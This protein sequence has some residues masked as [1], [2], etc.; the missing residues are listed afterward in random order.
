M[1]EN[2]ANSEPA[3][4]DVER[5]SRRGGLGLDEWFDRWPELFT[6]RWPET[7]GALPF[8]ESFRVEERTESDGTIVIRAEL[9][10]VDPDDGIEV[11]VDSG[12][13][14]IRAHREERSEDRENETL[15]SE[16]RYGSMVRSFRLPDGADEDSISAT[17]DSGI[18]E[19]SVPCTGESPTPKSIPVG[20]GT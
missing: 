16:F 3:T 7:F 5:S 18:L 15:R 9:P 19:V 10:G 11:T 14:T 2:T 17:C 1:T 13:L 12:R 6:R 4:T 20:K 8:A